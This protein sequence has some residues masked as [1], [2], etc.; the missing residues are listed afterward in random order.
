MRIYYR[1]SYCAR[2]ISRGSR[3]LDAELRRVGDVAGGAEGGDPGL[4]GVEGD[5]FAVGV[6]ESYLSGVAGFSPGADSDGAVLENIDLAAADG[7]VLRV[8]SATGIKG[9][10]A[11][12]Y[13]HGDDDFGRDRGLVAAG[14]YFDVRRA[15]FV[16]G[17]GIG[18][19]IIGVH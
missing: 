14:V 17:V 10:L 3:R 16:A 4:A 8:V 5:G 13:H 15:G 1:L 11:L 9:A 7:G 6:G 18:G 2:V 19:W 12:G